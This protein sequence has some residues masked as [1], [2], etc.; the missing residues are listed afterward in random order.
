MSIKA[1]ITDIDG[2]LVQ[3]R[4][5]LVTLEEADA[6]IPHSAIDAIAQLKQRGLHVVGVTGRD[7]AHA[8]DVLTVAGV[9]G[10]SAFDGG[11]TIRSIPDGELLYENSLPPETYD[12]VRSVLSAE[13]GETYPLSLSPAERHPTL[14]N[15]VWVV[16][17]RAVLEQLTKRLSQI[18]DI[19]FVI[20]EGA[21]EN[22]KVGLI[23]L[24]KGSTKG[25]ATQQILLMLGVDHSEVAC[26]GDGANDAPMFEEC[27]LSIAMGNADAMLKEKADFVV[28]PIDNDG[29]VEAVELIL[30]RV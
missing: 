15:S 25:T 4:P 11:A 23:V 21:G 14:M 9:S 28:A 2:T 18:E 5:D 8:H 16:F 17:K 30:D 22:D 3:Y 6:L 13:L 20:N 26:I 1:V 10:P 29:F 7:Y 27:G 12:A 19:Y 24:H